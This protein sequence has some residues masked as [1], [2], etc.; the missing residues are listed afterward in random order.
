MKRSIIGFII[1]CFLL[2]G[3]SIG[4]AGRSVVIPKVEIGITL[5]EDYMVITRNTSEDDPV[6]EKLGVSSKVIFDGMESSNT[7]M[8]A[9]AGDFT[10]E[11][12]VYIDNSSL[13]NINFS[14][15]LLNPIA[16]NI[17]K[18][19]DQIGLVSDG[20]EICWIRSC[21]FIKLYAHGKDNPVFK[22]VHYYTIQNY[23]ELSFIMYSYNGSLTEQDEALVRGVVD[24][25]SEALTNKARIDVNASTVRES[26]EIKNGDYQ[27][28]INEDGTITL[29]KYTGKQKEVIIPESIDNKPITGLEYDSFYSVDEMEKVVI[30]PSVKKINGNPFFWCSN[31]KEIVVDPRNESYVVKDGFLYSKDMKSVISS[32]CGNIDTLIYTIPEGVET[33]EKGAFAGYVLFDLVLPSTLQAIGE[34]AFNS[35]SALRTIIIPDNVKEIGDSAFARCYALTRCILPKEIESI[36]TLTFFSC[37]ALKEIQIPQSVKTLGNGCFLGS[38]L[39]EVVIPESISIIP[40]DA[41]ANCLNL[42]KVVIPGSVLS[43]SDEAF[44]GC[45]DDLVL[46]VE[47]GSYALSYAKKNGMRFS[48]TQ[49]EN[50]TQDTSQINQSISAKKD[51]ITYDVAQSK[52][53]ITL[54]N[55]WDY[56]D[57]N[58]EDNNPFIVQYGYSREEIQNDILGENGLFEAFNSEY[59]MMLSAYRL[60]AYWQNFTDISDEGITYI[61]DKY[62]DYLH[63]LGSGII[64][65]EIVRYNY[66]YYKIVEIRNGY[67]YQYYTII[68][69]IEYYISAFT[70][71]YYPDGQEKTIDRI[72]ESVVFIE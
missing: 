70:G 54:P 34:S 17:V 71:S 44:K 20:Y 21:H 58:F 68:D 25:A 5:P 3:I 64:S 19:Y 23:T 62:A 15:A 40:D 59:N 22:R 46:I 51:E 28:F 29:T 31:L 49:K 27:Y 14:D 12:C 37:A 33:I 35:N 32:P 56:V 13:N 10:K 43:I 61:G 47:D 9:M 11:I 63:S 48:I 53:R 66:P 72:V 2:C 65:K 57:K 42:Q 16:D 38:G 18:T 55:T 24:E 26:E 45:P 69:G 7:Y 52:L 41:F 60:E 36:G 50:S 39:T 6:F 8:T 1:L 67:N 30:P 4:N